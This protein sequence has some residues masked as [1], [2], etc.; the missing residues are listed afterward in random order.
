M[1]TTL[2]VTIGSFI[3]TNALCCS[4]TSCYCCCNIPLLPQFHVTH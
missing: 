2:K 4:P 1:E 3:F